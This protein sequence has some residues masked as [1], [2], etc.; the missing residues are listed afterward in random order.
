MKSNGFVY[1]G[2]LIL[3][4]RLGR[5]CEDGNP[6][7]SVGGSPLALSFFDNTCMRVSACYILYC[8]SHSRVRVCLL[9]AE[10]VLYTRVYN[11]VN[12]N[13][14]FFRG[15]QSQCMIAL[16]LPSSSLP[17]PL[18]SSDR[19]KCLLNSRLQSNLR[20]YA[21]QPIATC[22]CLSSREEQS[23]NPQSGMLRYGPTLF[24]FLFLLASH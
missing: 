14:T 7:F 12:C 15:Q 16:P 1:S 18:K 8:V 9:S 13:H 4:N 21:Q 24:F 3:Y 17:F 10:S 22:A 5:W 20:R 19:L 2:S 6:F 11:V 23:M